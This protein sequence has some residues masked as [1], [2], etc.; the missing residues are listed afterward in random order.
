MI[1]RLRTVASLLLVALACIW[2]GPATS[3]SAAQQPNRDAAMYATMFGVSEAEAERRL[4]LQAAAGDLEAKLYAADPNGFAGLWI[5][6]MPAFSFVVAFAHSNG[7]AIVDA[8]VAGPVRPSVIVANSAQF[9]LARLRGD[10]AKLAEYP[11]RPFA[12]GTDVQSNRVI[13]D[14]EAVYEFNSWLRASGHTLPQTVRV[15]TTQRLPRP[16]VEIYGGIGLS[17]SGCTSGFAVRDNAT[18]AMGVTTAAHCGN[19][20]SYL[21][22]D[23]PFQSENYGGWYD[24]QWHAA[25]T[26]GVRNWVMNPD[27]AI[28]SRTYWGSQVL[29][30]FLCKYGQTTGY[31]CGT[32]YQKDYIPAE[33]C[34]PN[35]RPVFMRLEGASVAGGDSGGPVFVNSSA[36]GTVICGSGTTI[37]Y[38]ATDYV[39]GGIGVTILTE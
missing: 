33:Y 31:N 18:G 26:F 37:I 14:V 7:E 13:V 9:S 6:H 15:R 19:L 39:E 24:V 23:L 38:T 29:G 28:W 8:V 27:Y 10:L 21:G 5:E 25:P 3:Q 2:I 12:A 1:T 16:T 11:N 4:T 34:V 20:N 22:E 30:S 17:G 35:A 36:H 32:L